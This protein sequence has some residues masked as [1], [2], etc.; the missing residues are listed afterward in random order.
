MLAAGV[1]ENST[2][3]ILTQVHTLSTNS[4]SHINSVI[5]QEWYSIFLA[6]LV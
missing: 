6:D 3:I 4:K 5:D 1:A 2:H